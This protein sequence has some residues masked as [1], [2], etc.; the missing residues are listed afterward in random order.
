L[1]LRDHTIKRSELPCV[2]P[3]EFAKFIYLFFAGIIAVNADR[4]NT[5]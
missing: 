4:P 3:Q 5:A 1:K 2:P